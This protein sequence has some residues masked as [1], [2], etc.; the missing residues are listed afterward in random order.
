[1]RSS[2]RPAPRNTTASAPTRPASAPRAVRSV[3]VTS[4]SY[5]RR[6]N[7]STNAG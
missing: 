3:T 2:G 6:V 5:A 4:G 1:M 7:A